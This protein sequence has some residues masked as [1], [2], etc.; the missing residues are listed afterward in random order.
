MLWLVLLWLKACGQLCPRIVGAARGVYLPL[1]RQLVLA[2]LQ[3]LSP[4]PRAARTAIMPVSLAA[5]GP[6][7]SRVMFDWLHDEWHERGFLSKKIGM[8]VLGEMKMA[9]AIALHMIWTKD[10]SPLEQAAA[11]SLADGSDF[12]SAASTCVAAGKPPVS[13]AVVDAKDFSP[14]PAVGGASASSCSTRSDGGFADIWAHNEDVICPLC[15]LCDDDL[16]DGPDSA[17]MGV[18]EVVICE[19]CQ[20]GFHV[21]CGGG[22]AIPAPPQSSGQ[23][24]GRR[25]MVCSGDGPQCWHVALRRV[26]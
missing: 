26:R 3:A 2:G 11:P 5:V 6:A 8:Q 25:R 17:S 9:D 21:A 10:E 14:C 1:G 20:G 7:F 23:P 18:R 22:L 15:E 4:S 12:L 13:A 16:R 19:S 24:S